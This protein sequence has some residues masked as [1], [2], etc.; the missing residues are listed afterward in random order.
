MTELPATKL[1][2]DVLDGLLGKE[3]AI[4]PSETALQS[5]DTVGGA[6]ATYVDDANALWAVV[7]WDLA[8]GANV[9]AAVA[10]VPPAAAEDAVEERYLPEHLL[11]NLGEVSNV[12]ASS[13]QLPGNPHLRLERTYRPVAS[14]PED[15][16]Q[17][18]YALGNRMDLDIDVPGYGAGRLSVSMRFN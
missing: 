2:K 11:E 9:G 18:L 5:A 13:F 3:V 17:L 1:I 16:V 15:A 8:A 7:G 4:R 14:A 12:L 6:L 10:L